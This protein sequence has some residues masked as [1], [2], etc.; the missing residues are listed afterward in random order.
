MEVEMCEDYL[1]RLKKCPFCGS[2][3]LYL[4]VTESRRPGRWSLWHAEVVCRDCFARRYGHDLWN[5]Q[6]AIESAI[7]MWNMRP[8]DSAPKQADNVIPDKVALGT[9]NDCL[10]DFHVIDRGDGDTDVTRSRI[11]V[12]SA[13]GTKFDNVRLLTRRDIYR[14]RYAQAQCEYAHAFMCSGFPTGPD[15]DRP[16]EDTWLDEAPFS[17]EVDRYLAEKLFPRE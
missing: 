9:D 4:D 8:D 10:V 1:K 12:F 16:S 6:D 11:R 7:K 3:D 13:Y 17:F 15:P 14:D 2:L 5:E